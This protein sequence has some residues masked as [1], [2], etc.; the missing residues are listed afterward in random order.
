M[1]STINVKATSI[2]DNTKSSVAAVKVIRANLIPDTKSNT[3]GGIKEGDSYIEGTEIEFAAVGAG[4]DNTAPISGDVRYVPVSWSVNSNGEW[5]TAPYTA[6]FTINNVG[7]YTLKVSYQKQTFNGTSWENIA[8]EIDTKTV[9]FSI[10][11]KPSSDQ[12]LPNSGEQAS[13]ILFLCVGII[14]AVSTK[15]MYLIKKK[16]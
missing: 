16:L 15:H 11:N 13:T 6:K 5:T 3:I 1:S 14:A 8:N 4:M 10:I 12:E 9:S 2:L 7:N